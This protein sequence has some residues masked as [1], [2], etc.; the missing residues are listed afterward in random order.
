MVFR[1]KNVIIMS[2][3]NDKCSQKSDKTSNTPTLNFRA[4]INCVTSDF[5]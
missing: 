3:T 5:I 4:L 1:L 2:D